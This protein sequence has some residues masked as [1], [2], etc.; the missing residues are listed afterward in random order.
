MCAT[1]AGPL[2][3]KFDGKPFLLDIAEIDSCGNIIWAKQFLGT[4]KTEPHALTVNSKGEVIVVGSFSA[5]TDF[6]LQSGNWTVN[7]NGGNAIYMVRFCLI[8]REKKIFE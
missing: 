2:D 1:L 4:S 6:D 3:G 8:P 7:T 5:T